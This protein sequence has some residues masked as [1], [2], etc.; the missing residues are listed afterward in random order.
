MM[1]SDKPDSGGGV[2][3]ALHL[4]AG[5]C[6]LALVM[7]GVGGTI[8]K[9][10]GPGGWLAQLVGGSLGNIGAVMLA[11]VGV[12]VF[13]W[14]AQDKITPNRRNRIGDWWVHVCALAGL[15]NLVQYLWQGSL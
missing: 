15:L 10:I 3:T 7:L 9:L 5:F 8:Y 12:A 6:L 1:Q 14:M 4:V 2:S 11:L 13:T